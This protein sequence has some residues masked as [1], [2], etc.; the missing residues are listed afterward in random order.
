[1]L[2]YPLECFVYLLWR[3]AQIIRQQFFEVIIKTR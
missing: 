2:Q 1:M 3:D